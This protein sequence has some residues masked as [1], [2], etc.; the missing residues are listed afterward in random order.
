MTLSRSEQFVAAIERSHDP[1]GTAK[2]VQKRHGSRP[3]SARD[4]KA[5]NALKRKTRRREPTGY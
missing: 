2:T 1:S 3:G 4:Q 5:L